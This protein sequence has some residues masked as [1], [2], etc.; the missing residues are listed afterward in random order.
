MVSVLA[1]QIA[2]LSIEKYVHPALY[3]PKKIPLHLSLRSVPPPVHGS[4][5]QWCFSCAETAAEPA[6][7][8]AAE[9]EAEPAAEPAAE[10]AAEPEDMKTEAEGEETKV[11]ENGDD[12]KAPNGIAEE[13]KPDPEAAPAPVPE[14][15]P[16][17]F[18]EQ[19]GQLDLQLTYLWRVH[20]VDY[21]AGVEHAEPEAYDACAGSRRK[22]RCTRPEDGEQPIKE[23]GQT[24]PTPWHVWQP[25][26]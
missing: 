13:P 22:L 25:Q 21:Y 12:A 19:L 6:A 18:E 10:S 14:E 5:A 2:I 3:N 20:G 1:L 7:E 26:M 23:E 17:T 9:L 4:A 8:P 24:R 11:D 15:A 16:K